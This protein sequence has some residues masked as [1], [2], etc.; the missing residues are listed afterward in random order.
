MG[1][2]SRRTRLAACAV[3]APVSA[4]PSAARAAD[5]PVRGNEG[6][7]DDGFDDEPQAGQDDF[8]PQLWSLSEQV[9]GVQ[10]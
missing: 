3:A 2:S 9:R 10:A 1:K 7:P 4:L 5:D 8:A 6:V